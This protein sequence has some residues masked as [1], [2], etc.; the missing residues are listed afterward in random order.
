VW[1]ADVECSS[2]TYVRSLAADLG[3]SLGG[4]AH[5]TSL[6]RTEVG[7]FVLAEAVDLET[8]DPERVLPLVEGVRHLPKLSVGEDLAALIAHGRVLDAGALGLEVPLPAS[9][10]PWAVVDGPGGLL[11]VYERRD[12]TRI[13]PAIVLAAAGG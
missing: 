3:R 10:G 2:G 6:R 5:L 13:K 7:P 12:D 9:A 11:A 4:G 8:L 1:T